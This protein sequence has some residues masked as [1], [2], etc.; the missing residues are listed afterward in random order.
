MAPYGQSSFKEFVVN[1]RTVLSLEKQRNPTGPTTR[2]PIWPWIVRILLVVLVGVVLWDNGFSTWRYQ[3]YLAI[4]TLCLSPVILLLAWLG[5]AKGTIAR[6]PGLS[7]LLLLMAGYAGIQSIDWVSPDSLFAGN[8]VRIQQWFLGQ[9]VDLS[10]SLFSES[11]KTSLER[12]SELASA[13]T[14]SLR[15]AS[16]SAWQPTTHVAPWRACSSVLY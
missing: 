13:Q 15:N 5:M 9:K 2:H 10:S 6:V 8:A 3:Y 7:I 12:S 14:L 4:G 11:M 1:W 16:R